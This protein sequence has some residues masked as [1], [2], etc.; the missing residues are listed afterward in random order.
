L[1]YFFIYEI[2]GMQSIISLAPKLNYN[3]L[4]VEVLKHFARLQSKDEQ[5]YLFL[6]Q[7]VCSSRLL[8]T[9]FA[10]LRVGS[11]PILQSALEK[12]PLFFILR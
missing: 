5:V 12:S 11:V 9:C 4:N 6:R 3:N 1:F 7:R 8:E 10:A 2:I